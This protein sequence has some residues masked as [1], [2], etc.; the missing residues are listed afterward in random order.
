MTVPQHGAMAHQ[1]HPN[2]S[3]R[4]DQTNLRRKH[5]QDALRT[6]LDG[7]AHVN[8]VLEVI[9]QA[10]KAYLLGDKDS[11]PALRLKMDG[12]LK[13]LNK[14]LPDVK[15]IDMT[16]QLNQMPVLILDFL[17]RN[18]PEGAIIDGELADEPAGASGIL[19]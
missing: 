12:H 2:N 7:E 16:A 4:H 13:L 14:V 18:A 6:T 5:A 8:G 17:G 15:Q 10:E 19:E 9:S 11:V 1:Q 3:L